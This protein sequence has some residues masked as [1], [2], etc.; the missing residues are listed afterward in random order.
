MTG[1]T[2]NAAAGGGH[3]W[4]FFRV[5]GFD[6]A[7]IDSGA[8][9]LA[10][11]QLDQKLWVALACPVH[12]IELDQRSLELIDGDGDGRVRAP[13]LLEAVAWAGKLLRDPEE[14]VRGAAPLPLSA[15]DTGTAEGAAI[16]ASA[17]RIVETMGAARTTEISL[18]QAASALDAFSRARLNGDGVVPAETV[19]EKDLSAAIADIV[20][21]TGGTTDRSGRAG[22]DKALLERFRAQAAA[23]LAWR[24]EPDADAGI[25]PLGEKTR[26]A[27]AAVAAV[28]DKVRD[29]F[30]RCRLAAY[31]GR[32]AGVLNRSEGDY[33]ALALHDLGEALD[34][35][36]AFPLAQAA[37]G[38]PLPLDEQ[39]NP[40]WTAR[41][42]ALREDA[43]APLLG[44]RDSL[45]E[46]DWNALQERLAAYEAWQARKPAALA[47]LGDERLRGLLADALAGRI[48]EL[49]AADEALRPEVDAIGQV[50]RLLRYRRDL[51]TL[52]NNFV[53]FAPFYTRRGKAT[54]QAG[55]LYLDGRSF[56][57]CVEVDDDAKHVTLATHARIYLVYCLCRRRG[58][59]GT[60]KIAAAVTNGDADNLMV[61]RNG[62]FYDRKGDDWDATVIRIVE[63]PISIRQAFWAPYKQ[64]AKL[65][66]EQV[67][68]LAGAR[69]KGVQDAMA[70]GIARTA[71]NAETAAAQPPP[72]PAA[73]PA[74][75]PAGTPGAFDPAR[76]A[77][78]FAAIGLAVGALGTA[79]AAMVTG[80]LDLSWWQMPLAVAGLILLISG[81]SMA[82]AA[83]KL[84]Q[85]NLAPILDA[86]GWAVNAR[87]KIN[88]PFGASLTQLAH[89]PEGA[90]RAVRDPYG[91]KRTPWGFYAFAALVALGAILAWRLGLFA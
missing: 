14:L 45:S 6:Q 81:P 66:G 49:I 44:A 61:G 69:S 84:R 88:I 89:L 2:S 42:A 39:V 91:E 74:P 83:M 10:L 72:S 26:A 90:E 13:E 68:K 32:A 1:E 35:L 78:I 79:L 29:Y 5:G 71:A 63:H 11:P 65:I 50:E 77:G 25:L 16:A 80:F 48:A 40:A 46:A 64:A 54:F 36:A 51:L 53:S 23:W 86:C 47:D 62:L 85:R 82:I 55:T 38:R 59:T 8:D 58:G 87:A 43:V 76:T 41:I 7:R 28:R 4:R 20:K 33:A 67:E 17:S 9:L 60:M 19:E 75:P 30:A 15:I 34:E 52:A 21:A 27:A 57:L 56:E 12:G 73:T 18:A 70:T 24:G 37:P 22:L 31:D 3:R